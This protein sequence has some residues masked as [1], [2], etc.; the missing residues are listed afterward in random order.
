MSDYAP[1]FILTPEMQKI[2]RIKMIHGTL[3]LAGNTLSESQV[4]AI[5][6]SVYGGVNGRVSGGVN[7]GV[8]EVLAYIREHS[9]C[10]ANAIAEALSIPLRSVQ[11]YLGVLKA[12]GHVEFRGAPKNGGYWEV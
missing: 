8:D 10:R 12:N 9:G 3:T 6:E 5:Y 2:N 4:A 7:A 11:R 1:R